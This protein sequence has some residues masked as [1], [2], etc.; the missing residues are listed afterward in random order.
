MQAVQRE[1]GPAVN[2]QVYKKYL[3]ACVFSVSSKFKGPKVR[4]H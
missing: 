2:I 3:F 1:H 4:D